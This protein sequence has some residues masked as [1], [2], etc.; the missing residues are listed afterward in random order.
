MKVKDVDVCNNTP[1]QTAILNGN[2]QL[3]L[4][5]LNSGTNPNELN[6]YLESP[7]HMAAI[8]NDIE[9]IDNLLNLGA[10]VNAHG[11]HN[12]TALHHAAI[13][14]YYEIVQMLLAAGA[15]PNAVNYNG[16]T[17]LHLANLKGYD[18]DTRFTHQSEKNDADYVNVNYVEVLKLLVKSGAKSDVLNNDGLT[19]LDIA[20]DNCHMIPS[21]WSFSP[22]LKEA[23]EFLLN[24]KVCSPEDLKVGELPLM[25]EGD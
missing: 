6:D 10:D 1:L 22:Q 7:L 3:A 21:Y 4:D 23:Y 24:D 25:G 2:S 20:K 18:S 19:P 16:N 5:L 11:L 13:H 9:L 8:A 12:C 17:P 14:G 15:N